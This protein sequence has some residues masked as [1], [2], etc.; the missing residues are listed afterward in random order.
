MNQSDPVKV[1]FFQN[2]STINPTRISSGIYL[3][4]N[5][6]GFYSLRLGNSLYESRKEFTFV[7]SSAQNISLRGSGRAALLYCCPS[8]L[9]E[10]S[11]TS[12]GRKVGSLFPGGPQN[13]YKGFFLNSNTAIKIDDH[14]MNISREMDLKRTDS[15]DMVQVHLLEIFLLLKRAGLLSKSDLK[16]WSLEQRIWNIEDVVHY[17]EE[18]FDGSFSLNDLASRCALNSSYFSRSFREKA[19]VPLF[20]YINRLRIDR[21]CLLLKNSDMTI[22]DIAFS[23]GYNNLSFFNRYFKKLKDCSPGEYRRKVKS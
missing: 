1:Q 3:F 16:K 20:E 11:K 7:I 6:S 8:Y 23:V 10:I 22:L 12:W 4:T 2:S 14:Y 18:N 19:G 5:F 15:P 13:D 21:A 9:N 17:V